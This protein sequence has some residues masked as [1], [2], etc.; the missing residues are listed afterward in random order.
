MSRCLVRLH[1][2]VLGHTYLRACC[3]QLGLEAAHVLFRS[4]ECI[5]ESIGGEVR[6]RRREERGKRKEDNVCD[7]E[8]AAS[9]NVTTTT[10]SE[11]EDTGSSTAGLAG[12]NT[13]L[14]KI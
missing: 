4:V 10:R 5:P 8:S 14:F 13:S 1:R 9:D 2:V 6:S 3:P 7:G 12:I 11:M